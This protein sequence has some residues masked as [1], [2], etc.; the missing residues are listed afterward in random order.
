MTRRGYRH[1]RTLGLIS[2]VPMLG[3]VAV[4]LYFALGTGWQT[5]LAKPT[6]ASQPTVTAPVPT[7]TAQP[8]AT[9]T[10]VWSGAAARLT[11][12]ANGNA[13]AGI[14]RTVSVIGDAANK[15]R[16]RFVHASSGAQPMDVYVNGIKL[17]AGRG[18]T[19]VSAYTSL[20]KGSYT[21]YGTSTGQDHATYGKP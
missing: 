3:L 6:V 1:L 9:P 2:I 7:A 12:R 19:S 15:A 8:T 10:S 14:T 20:P 11:T 4:L 13:G 16:V 18:Y 17:F 21:A 5:I